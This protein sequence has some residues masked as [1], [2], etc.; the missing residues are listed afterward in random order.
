LC[1]QKKHLSVCVFLAGSSL[2]S[3]LLKLPSRRVTLRPK[4]V[5]CSGC[6]TVPN[7]VPYIVLNLILKDS[8]KTV[9]TGAPVL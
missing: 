2:P 7:D 8:I 3:M 4:M 6:R 1:C 9:I 5:D